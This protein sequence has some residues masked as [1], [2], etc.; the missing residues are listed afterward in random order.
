M[1]TPSLCPHN[2]PAITTGGPYYR[3]VHPNNFQDGRVLSSAFG[4]QDTGCHL[5]ISLNDGARTT[6]RRC[7]LEYTQSGELSSVAVVEISLH[8]IE[9]SGSD[10]VVDEPN[11]Q[12]H[13]HV[14]AIYE[15]S[16][17]RRQQRR[18]AQFL[19]TAANKKGPAYLPDDA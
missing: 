17:S 11:E 2:N 8:E 7:Y 9:A 3:Q 4:L 15:S 14:D 18:V 10:R 19:A 13:A 6:A 5:C 16:L 1:G 12:T